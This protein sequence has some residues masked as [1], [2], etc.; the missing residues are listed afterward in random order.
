MVQPPGTVGMPGGQDKTAIILWELIT[1]ELGPLG[2]HVT[3]QLSITQRR[4]AKQG[5]QGTGSEAGEQ[6]G[7]LGTRSGRMKAKSWVCDG[8]SGHL[9]DLREN[10]HPL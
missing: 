8:T 10:N 2:T 9:G 7:L 5:S 6:G 3:P 4:K 1:E